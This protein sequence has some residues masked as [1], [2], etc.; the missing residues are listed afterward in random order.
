M[1]DAR[2]RTTGS[3]PKPPVA[4]SAWN[5]N[6]LAYYYRYT[7]DRTEHTGA[8]SCRACLHRDKGADAV[9]FP[10]YTAVGLNLPTR[11]AS[12]L[13]LQVECRGRGRSSKVLLAGYFLCLG[14]CFA[15]QQDWC[16]T[17]LFDARHL[18]QLTES[19][20]R[21]NQD[22]SIDAR[23]FGHGSGHAHVLLWR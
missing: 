3:L 20:R 10:R 6:L 12:C 18:I 22:T 8:E 5:S 19:V 16:S 7:D 11:T 17:A 1:A 21:W 15:A 2:Q 14:A 23:S 4:S 9:L 13:R